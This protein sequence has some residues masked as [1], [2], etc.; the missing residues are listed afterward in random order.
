MTIPQ[1]DVNPL[2]MPMNFKDGGMASSVQK[3]QSQGRLNDSML[4]HMN[5]R[6]VAGLQTLARQNGTSLTINPQT[7]LPE[8]F[9]LESILPAVA[10]AA[11]TPVLGPAAPLVVGGL[12]ALMTGSLEK[13]LMMGLGAYGGAGLAS[14]LAGTAANLAAPA[15]AAAPT[16]AVGADVVAQQAAAELAAANAAAQATQAATNIAP[17]V[18]FSGNVLGIDEMASLTGG[19]GVSAGF[20]TT[21]PRP[22]VSG[23]SKFFEPDENV[24]YENIGKGLKN[25]FSS[26]ENAMDFLGKNKMNL[27]MSAAPML[28]PETPQ[29]VERRRA[30]IRPYEY[31]VENLSGAEVDPFGTEEERLRGRFVAREPYY[32]AKGGLMSLAE[33]GSTSGESSEAPSAP[34]AQTPSSLLINLSPSEAEVY[35]N[36]FAVQQMAGV[37]LSMPG[38]VPYGNAPSGIAALPSTFTMSPM[39]SAQPTAQPNFAY[40]PSM[41]GAVPALDTAEKSYS[42]FNPVEAFTKSTPQETKQKYGINRFTGEVYDD[43]PFNQVRRHPEPSEFS[44]IEAAIYVNNPSLYKGNTLALENIINRMSGSGGGAKGGLINNGKFSS[45][46][47]NKRK[48]ISRSDPFYEFGTDMTK[49]AEEQFVDGGMTGGYSYDPTTNS[50][51]M[52]AGGG[53]TALKAGGLRE[54]AFIVPADVISHLGNGSSEAGMKIVQERLKGRPIKGPG[55]GMSDSIPT[56]IAGKQPARVANEE[57]EIPPEVVAALGGG[58]LEKGAKKLY[59][60]MDK[61]RQDRTGKKK[62]APAVKAEKYMPA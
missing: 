62:Q 11:L 59:E 14:G 56:T 55:D 7:G 33:G 13:G 4:V 45:K 22:P 48:K 2:M 39:T 10:G 42:V 50:Y 60:M 19:Q 30:M 1:Y 36:I 28:I 61:I 16:A 43:R 34:T 15:A 25:V 20:P 29:E 35:R 3:V 40:T 18:D 37:P 32:A 27:A 52:M 54:G 53:L 12:G 17:P 46:T 31:Q 49:V 51:K 5:P 9:N 41:V 26:G 58:S 21:V 44:P 8:A 24:T 47:N 23:L 57:A 6:E 38:S